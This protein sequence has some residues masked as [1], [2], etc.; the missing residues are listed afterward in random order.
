M[1]P[2][3]TGM[4]G[5]SLRRLAPSIVWGAC[6]VLFVVRCKSPESKTQAKLEVSCGFLPRKKC[7]G[8]LNHAPEETTLRKDAKTFMKKGPNTH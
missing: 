7:Q 6:N 2:E 3:L 4:C 5:K 8:H 1:A